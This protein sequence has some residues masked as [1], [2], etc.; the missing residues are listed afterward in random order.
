MPARLLFPTEVR[1]G[2]RVVDG[3]TFDY[4]LFLTPHRLSPEDHALIIDILT[5]GACLG[6]TREVVEDN[7]HGREY[8]AV[9]KVTNRDAPDSAVGTLQYYDWCEEGKPQ[10]WMNDLCR[11]R[12]PSTTKSAMSPVAILIDLFEGL[13]R[14]FKIPALHLAVDN[15]EPG[16]TKLPDIYVGYGFAHTFC[17]AE[18]DNDLIMEKAIDAKS[19]PPRHRRTTRRRRTHHP[20]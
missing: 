18:G 9:G 3:I 14:E 20:R 19:E 12:D 16:S 1:R 10:L 8:S 7:L 17:S 2:I 15:K 11:F 6:I 13:G 4:V 5:G